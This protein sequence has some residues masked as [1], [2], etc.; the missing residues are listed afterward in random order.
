M[1]RETRV[2]AME[3]SV[4]TS[5]VVSTLNPNAP[6]FIPA[7]YRVPEDFSPEWWTLMETSTAFRGCWM[8]ERLAGSEEQ[9]LFDED[10][11]EL[12]DLEEFL[13]YQEQQQQQQE[14]AAAQELLDLDDV[15]DDDVLWEDVGLVNVSSCKELMM[16]VQKRQS[17]WCKPTKAHDKIR[18]NYVNF[19]RK[20]HMYRIQQPRAVM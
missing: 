16:K 7:A 4:K 1:C 12:A 18:S 17:H 15:V 3:T 8:S 20:T 14:E 13:E 6:L 9:V 11:E 5:V 2:D 19:P 10:F